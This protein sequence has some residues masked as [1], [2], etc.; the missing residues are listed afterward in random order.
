MYFRQLLHEEHSCISYVIGCVSLGAAAVVDPQGDVDAYIELTSRAG[1]P[2]TH[3][4]DTHVH[5]DHYSGAA[6]LA[7]RAGVPLH[8]G[9]GAEVDFAYEA[10]DDGDVLRIGNRSIRVLHTPGHTPEHVSLMVDDWFVLTGDTLFVGDVGRVDLT[11]APTEDE[12]LELR[13]KHLHAS[14]QTL[15][16][17]PDHVEVYPGHYAGS[18]CGRGMDGKPSSTIGRERLTNEAL[19]LDVDSFVELQLGNLPPVPQDFHRIKEANRAAIA[20]DNTRG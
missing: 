11:L 8:L 12:E 19:A 6:E 3:V 1:T 2:I 14:L 20:A 17:L 5:A 10:L 13:A 7:D 18:V 16:E 15:L 9:P 4:I